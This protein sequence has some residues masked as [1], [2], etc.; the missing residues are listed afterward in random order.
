VDLFPL[1]RPPTDGLLR[2]LSSSPQSAKIGLLLM[3]RRAPQLLLLATI[4]DWGAIILAVFA[5]HL[6]RQAVRRLDNTSDKRGLMTAQYALIL[7]WANIAYV[8]FSF[9]ASPFLT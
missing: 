6:A 8:I 7:G 3:A 5:I 4:L 9:V 2:W 1:R